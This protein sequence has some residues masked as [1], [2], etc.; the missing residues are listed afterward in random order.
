MRDHPYIYGQLLFKNSLNI[1]DNFFQDSALHHEIRHSSHF[2]DGVYLRLWFNTESELTFE[3]IETDE[4]LIRGEAISQHD[5]IKLSDLT[6]SIFSKQKLKHRLE[7]YS[8]NGDEIGYY[9]Y[10]WTK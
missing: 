4:I 8:S 2:Q 1:L 5:L 6:S 7:L 10:N 3:K 9:N